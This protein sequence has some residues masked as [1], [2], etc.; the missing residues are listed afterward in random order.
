M[1]Q[2]PTPTKKEIVEWLDKQITNMKHYDPRRDMEDGEHAFGAIV[3]EQE[4]IKQNQ[5]VEEIKRRLVDSF[6]EDEVLK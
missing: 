4:K 6:F 5:I 2:K 3:R 1:T